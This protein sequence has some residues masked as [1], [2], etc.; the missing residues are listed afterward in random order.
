MIYEL[1]ILTREFL[2]VR[3]INVIS[4]FY[5]TVVRK[6]YYCH[7]R[8]VLT[9]TSLLDTHTLVVINVVISCL[10]FGL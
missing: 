8:L 4:T 5:I 3:F 7:T 9:F 1:L 10:L 2:K 6:E